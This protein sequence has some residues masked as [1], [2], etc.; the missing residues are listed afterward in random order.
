MKK[1]IYNLRHISIKLGTPIKTSMPLALQFRI[2]VIK[3]KNEWLWSTIFKELFTPKV[4][5]IMLQ[6]DRNSVGFKAGEHA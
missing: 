5:A 3:H 1:N 6:K 4:A 2:N